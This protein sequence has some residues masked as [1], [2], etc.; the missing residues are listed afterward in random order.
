MTNQPGYLRPDAVGINERVGF[1]NSDA[2][3]ENK[4]LGLPT[5]KEPT[6]INDLRSPLGRSS[7]EEF[8]RQTGADE[9]GDDLKAETGYSTYAEY[10]EAYNAKRPYLEGILQWFIPTGH[11]VDT[12]GKSKFT[13][14]DLSHNKNSQSRV[15]T[16]CES[17][18]ATSIVRTVR[19]PPANVDV[20]IV[21]WNAAGERA[22]IGIEN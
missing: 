8:H 18:S 16:R 4:R 22:R 9:L 1:S 3:E 21:L 2:V 15:V 20:Q 11:N 5:S 6:E 12:A 17:I 19:H 7:V 14:L 10:L 13:V